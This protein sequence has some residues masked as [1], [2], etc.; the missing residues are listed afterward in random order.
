MTIGNV[1]SV[2]LAGIS[3]NFAPPDALY[4][5]IRFHEPDEF[6]ESALIED[7]LSELEDDDI[8]LDVGAHI[9]YH[10]CFAAEATPDGQVIAVEAHPLN[11]YEVLKNSRLNEHD[12]KV[13][14]FALSN[15]SGTQELSID[16]PN[17]GGSTHSL[18]DRSGDSITISTHRGEDVIETPPS[19]IK[20]DVEG[21]EQLVLEG[22]ESLL[23]REECRIVYCELH[24]PDSE[25]ASIE[26]FGGSVE[27]IYTILEDSGFEI[28]EL[29]HREGKYN[30]SDIKAVKQ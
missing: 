7:M 28:R 23:N 6:D 5:N 10:S 8:V 19:V 11:S 9:G 24:H 25:N 17:V 21:A 16:G 26:D 4:N 3:V 14:S 2:S 12:T 18:A 20:I 13:Y 15:E 22:M 27:E 30:T 29:D 1:V